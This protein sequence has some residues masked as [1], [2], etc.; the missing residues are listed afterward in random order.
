MTLHVREGTYRQD[1]HKVS[2]A[3]PGVLLKP[4]DLGRW[5][6][7][8]WESVCDFAEQ[9]GAGECDTESLAGMCR[10]Y[11]EYRRITAQVV[12]V[13]PT[14]D[15]HRALLYSAA[16]CWRQFSE[17]AGRFGLTPA[18]RAKL[19]SDLGVQP[20]ALDRM[21]SRRQDNDA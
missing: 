17:M 7:R 2:P 11:Q 15:K 12:R 13:G 1:R 16:L 10:W 9:A 18:D 5:G 19:K 8:L 14:N 4:K 20:T 6:N 21:L 3:A